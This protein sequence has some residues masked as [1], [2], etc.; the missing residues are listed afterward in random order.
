[1]RELKHLKDHISV[2]VVHPDMLENGWTFDKNFKNS[3]GDSLYNKK[4]LYE[5]YQI[6]S[7][8]ITT[9][10]TVPIL[11]DKKTKKIV[12]NES[13][14]ILRIF[15]SGFNK[16][17][18]NYDDFYP[19]EMRVEIEKINEDIYANIN[20]GVYKTGFAKSQKAYEDAVYNLFHTLD[21]MEDHLKNK[22]FVRK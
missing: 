22:V 16:L 9:K 13:S 11:W 10:V 8:N 17:T 3:T 7:S 12:N 21:L 6:H 5:I 14:E 18:N 19:E 4:F 2:D 15:N 1:M 20:N